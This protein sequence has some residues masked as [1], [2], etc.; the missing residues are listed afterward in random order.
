MPNVITVFLNSLTKHWNGEIIAIIVSGYGDDGAE[1]LSGIKEAGGITIA[2]KPGT[3][4]HPNMPESA[5]ASGFIDFILSPEDI[6]KEI[7]RVVNEG[8]R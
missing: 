1:S 5:I 8:K 4:E 2:Q 7:I 6:A 3:A